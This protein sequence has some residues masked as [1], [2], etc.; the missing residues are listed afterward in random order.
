MSLVYLEILGPGTWTAHKQLVSFSFYIVSEILSRLTS[1]RDGLL[2]PDCV[3]SVNIISI[4][5]NIFGLYSV[6]KLHVVSRCLFCQTNTSE[7]RF[8]K[9][10]LEA[11]TSE[12]INPDIVSTF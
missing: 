11:F 5:S 8:L 4:P 1:H 2:R 10:K 3:R 12:R 7:L 6:R 9:G